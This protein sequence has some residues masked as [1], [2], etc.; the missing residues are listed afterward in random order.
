MQG[1]PANGSPLAHREVVMGIEPTY[2]KAQ[3]VPSQSVVSKEVL[4]HVAGIIA[5]M[6]VNEDVQSKAIVFLTKRIEWGTAKYGQP[7]HTFDG[8]DTLVDALDEAGDL[9]MYLGKAAMEEECEENVR[10]FGVAVGLL[11]SVAARRLTKTGTL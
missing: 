2:T 7:L 11:I 1:C 3:P 5:L 6:T 8:R 9:V 4:P 10:L